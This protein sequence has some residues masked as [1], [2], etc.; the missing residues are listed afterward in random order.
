MYVGSAHAISAPNLLKKLAMMSIQLVPTAIKSYVY[1]P[2]TILG[3]TW[4]K[5]AKLCRVK[6]CFTVFV[7][8]GSNP[9]YPPWFLLFTATACLGLVTK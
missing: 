6:I 3:L 4:A 9:L 2:Y 7:K 5:V 8:V 1:Y